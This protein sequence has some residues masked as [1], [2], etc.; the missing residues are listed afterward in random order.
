MQRSRCLFYI[1]VSLMRR[2]ILLWMSQ[3]TSLL[4]FRMFIAR[5][6]ACKTDKPMVVHVHDSINHIHHLEPH[7]GCDLL[8]ELEVKWQHS[9]P[10][11]DSND[12]SQLDF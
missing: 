1:L 11:H 8:R 5:T 2:S 7:R 6:G 9:F 3:H 4:G 10:P 12:G